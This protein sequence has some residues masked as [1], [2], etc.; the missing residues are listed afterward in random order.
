M[1]V[2]NTLPFFSANCLTENGV[3]MASTKAAGDTDQVK[4]LPV[5]IYPE[6]VTSTVVDFSTLL[7]VVL[8]IWLLHC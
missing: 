4:S 2:K 7:F 3:V 5:G 6:P 8:L 1:E